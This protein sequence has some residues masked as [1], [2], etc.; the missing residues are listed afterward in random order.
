MTV[1]PAAIAAAREAP[2][3]GDRWTPIDP[4]T[5]V[6]RATVE[7]DPLVPPGTFRVATYSIRTL[8]WERLALNGM[9][10]MRLTPPLNADADGIAFKVV[11][12]RNYYSP[13]NIAD[14]GIRF[15]D[16]YVRTGNPAFLE[17]A[18]LR[19]AK[20]HD[21]GFVRGGALFIPYQFDYPN[22][23]LAAPWVSAY[24]QGFAL[25]LLVRLYRV[26]GEDAY[27]DDAQA[28]F[29]SF[30]QLGPGSRPWVAYVVNGDL[31]LEQ[32][33]SS[34]PTHV[35]NGFNFATFGLY[36]YERLTRDPAAHQ[37]L[38]G[39]LSTLRR[40]A[41]RYRVPGEVSLYDLVH[42]TQHRSY[43]DVVV[44]QVGDLGAISRDPYFNG[45]TKTLQAD[46][47]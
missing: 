30:R 7:P 26:T 42:R 31:W 15:V 28:V 34:R 33:P 23:R 6:S 19:A 25:S 9:S 44:W 45:L 12:G 16:S 14:E 41:G 40:Q 8:A 46:G 3:M 13:G 5:L 24:S 10:L 1:A 38:Q 4:A 11:N 29:R 20:L 32:Y 22:E 2:T 21:I 47:A 36:D 37:L 35:L 39:A 27:L 17:R 18:A 43:H